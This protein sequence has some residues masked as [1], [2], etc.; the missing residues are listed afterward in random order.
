MSHVLKI[1]PP[2]PP[3]SITVCPITQIPIGWSNPVLLFS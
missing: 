1:S 2:L 3:L